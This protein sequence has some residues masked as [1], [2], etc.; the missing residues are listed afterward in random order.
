M[1]A[2]GCDFRRFRVGAARCG[3]RSGPGTVA[4]EPGSTRDCCRP[5]R[6]CQLGHRADA[7]RLLAGMP[8][9]LRVAGESVGV[10]ALVAAASTGLPATAWSEFSWSF[11]SA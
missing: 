6:Q 3:S 5:P 1:G 11:V 2:G 4:L 10:V 7:T 8:A 9:G